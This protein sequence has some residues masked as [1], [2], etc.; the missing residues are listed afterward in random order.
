M[1][2][3]RSRTL[4]LQDAATRSAYSSIDVAPRAPEIY[5]PLDSLPTPFNIFK[6]FFPVW[7]FEIIVYATNCQAAADPNPIK[8]WSGP[9]NVYEMYCYIATIIYKG[10]HNEDEVRDLWNTDERLGPTHP[11]IREHISSNRFEQL[12]RYFYFFSREEVDNDSLRPHEKIGPLFDHFN[13]V[14]PQIWTP[15][16]EL[17]IDESLQM[18][19]HKT[20]KDTVRIKEKAAK[21]GV[22]YYGIGE[23]GYLLQ[24]LATTHKNTVE[25]LDPRWERDYKLAPTHAVVPELVTRIQSYT[26]KPFSLYID[27]LWGYAKIYTTLRTLG[28]PC[29]GT[30]SNKRGTGLYKELAEKKKL[31]ETVKRNNGVLWGDTYPYYD[32]DNEL[33][34]VGFQDRGL[35]TMYTTQW[36]G[37]DKVYDEKIRPGESVTDSKICRAIYPPGITALWCQVPGLAYM[38]TQHMGS[39]DDVDKRRSYNTTYRTHRRNWLPHFYWLLDVILGNAYLVAEKSHARDNPEIAFAFKTQKLFRKQLI[40]QMFAAGARTGNISKTNLGP[41]HTR[42]NTAAPIH[43]KG[44]LGKR[45]LCAACIANGS[46]KTRPRTRGSKR[47]ALGELDPNLTRKQPPKI[48]FGCKAC[49]IHLCKLND[50]CWEAHLAAVNRPVV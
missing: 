26:D 25:D 46:W 14:S 21:E 40:K 7:I 31:S 34:Q 19:F 27:N 29:T 1:E 35:V 39:I 12:S 37:D 44:P 18:S 3:Y 13:S 23:K 38:Y 22:K 32:K 28:V 41:M 8:R 5:L 2:P 49:Q 43:E 15:G 9:T 4:W 45:G 36:Q 17:A 24:A 6:L 48:Q 50:A 30:V 10:I 16:S 42:V 20:N 11:Q 47:R 33:L